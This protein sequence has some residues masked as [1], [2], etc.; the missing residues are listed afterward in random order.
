MAGAIYCRVSTE[1]QAREGTSLE[2]QKE[3]CLKKANELGYE[4]LP[5]YQIAEVYSGLTL[6]RPKLVNLRTW[7]KNKEIDAIVAYSTDRLSRDP[8][9]LLL[10]AEECQKAGIPLI[11]VTEPLDNSME[12]QLLGFI[13]GWAS[14]LEAVKIAERTKRGKRTRAESGKLPA[15]SHA[16]LYGYDYIPGKGIGEGVRYVNETQA[17][18]VREAFRWLVEEQLS[19]YS[20]TLRLR[21]LEAPP[22]T[23]NGRWNKSTVQRM[24]RNKAYYGKTYAFTMTYA[25]PKNPK[26]LDRKHKKTLAI[27]KPKDQ[28]L[29]IPNATP[30]IISEEL[31][32]AAQNQLKKNIA[33][34]R[35]NTKRDYL[36][37]GRIHC[38][39][40][41]RSYWSYV[42]TRHC[43]GNVHHYRRYHCSGKLSLVSPVHCDNKSYAADYLESVV[44]QQVEEIL[45]DPVT[46][47]VEL[48]KR[49]GRTQES[50]LKGDLERI[51]AMLKNRE[52]Q[53]NRIW[54]AF[55]LTGDEEKFKSDI[56]S[57]E[58]EVKSLEDKRKK[59]EDSIEE[60]RHFQL[61]TEQIMEACEL[62]SRN[63]G[64][65][66][67]ADK[68]LAL[69]ALQIE[70]WLDGDNIT[71]KGAI[72]IPSDAI[73]TTQ[74]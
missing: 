40:C 12:G 57:L 35:R 31:F 63:L 6:E 50:S 59:L 4:I 9:H 52:R 46:V 21:A 71:I 37:H 34:A 48:Q 42:G 25:E 24:L 14:K 33:L 38:A 10:L 8:V 44:W 29:E 72:P 49:E 19:T 15:N 28:W 1:D 56:R 11:F 53:K 66:T 16:R 74:Y 43:A 2:S 55:E 54:K 13:R 68:R 3:A 65:L 7:I 27:M 39:R 51:A 23:P 30:P 36:L 73:A 17:H 22:P 61:H 41:G 45:S 20:V 26:K 58:E 67:F 5:Q 69:E 32:N 60:N 47:L 70:A 62:V 18:W 64:N